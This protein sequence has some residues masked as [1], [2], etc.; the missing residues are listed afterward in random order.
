MAHARQAVLW[1]LECAPGVPAD[2]P[3][4]VSDLGAGTCAASLGAHLALVEHAGAGQDMAIY[5]VDLDSSGR[6]FAEAFAALAGTTSGGPNATACKPAAGPIARELAQQWALAARRKAATKSLLSSAS[7]AHTATATATVNTS[8]SAS[9]QA[10]TPSAAAL[11][12]N[13][14]TDQYVSS[15][16]EGV[17]GLVQSLFEAL[18]ERSVVGG[19]HLIVASFSLQYLRN[20]E[21]IE[22]E[23]EN[24]RAC[25][26]SAAAASRCRCVPL[27]S[28]SLSKP[29]RSPARTGVIRSLSRALS[30]F[31]ATHSSPRLLP[32]SPAPSSCS[33]SRVLAIYSAR[34][35][36]VITFALAFMASTTS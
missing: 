21:V 35:Q 30:L 16:K 4:V 25:P 19:P 27:S 11:L 8:A 10:T 3:L 24:D 26:A 14:S 7:T 34:R 36:K 18:R 20:E 2:G 6:R 31:S 15:S 5:P 1:L 13:Q 17:I 23:R 32:L 9:A 22:G 28:R 33:S 12:P 29:A